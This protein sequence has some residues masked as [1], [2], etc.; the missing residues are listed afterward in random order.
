[1]SMSEA[2]EDAW[3]K[4]REM[5]RN[6]PPGTAQPQWN[7]NEVVEAPPPRRFP[8]EVVVGLLIAGCVAAGLYFGYEYLDG[9][10]TIGIAQQS[11][12]QSTS[13]SAPVASPAPAASTAKTATVR[14]GLKNINVRASA[15]SNGAVV[16]KLSGGQQ[17][18][19]IAESGDWARIRFQTPGTTTEG[20]VR[21]D[22]LD[23]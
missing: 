13:V 16:G 7:P 22:L 18:E 15:A 19:K 10:H 23:N 2:D 4:V 20:W 6:S 11:S 1:M 8:T 21:R 5:V 14:S 12:A 17:V 9:L 3:E